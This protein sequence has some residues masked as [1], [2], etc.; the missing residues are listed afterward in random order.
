MPV[1]VDRGRR[2]FH[3]VR[4]QAVRWKRMLARLDESHSFRECSAR[5]ES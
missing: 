3:T 2:Y 1:T 4:H 5:A